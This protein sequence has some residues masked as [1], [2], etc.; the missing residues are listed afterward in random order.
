MITIQDAAV[1]YQGK[2]L[3]SGLNLAL[4]K[5]QWI[6]LL[7][8][9]GVGKSSLLRFIGG[10]LARQDIQHGRVQAENG[11]P[12][13]EQIAYMGQI[14]LLLP[15][16]SIWDN[17]LLG[18][19]LKN[20]TRAKRQLIIEQAKYLLAKTGIEHASRLYPS[21]LSGGIAATCRT[22]TYAFAG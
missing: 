19:K 17:V 18:L 16:L 12:V 13:S 20:H 21:Q 6:A 3:F 7:G 10:L 15:W 11:M 1:C 4:K 22:R 8:P 9:S 2:V 5:G 14:D